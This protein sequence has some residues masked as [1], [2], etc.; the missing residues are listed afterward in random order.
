MRSFP[1]TFAGMMA[2]F[3]IWAAHFGILYG[4]NGLACARGLE[5]VRV[6]GFPLV[7]FT[8]AAATAV[9]LLLTGAV[10]VRALLGSAPSPDASA[11]PRRFIR[12]FTAAA[13]AS[14]LVAILWNGLPALQVPPCG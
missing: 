14:A 9:A 2:A 5:G 1:A 12:W 8:V 13:A 7:P 11:A 10:L 4:V 3:L 6:L